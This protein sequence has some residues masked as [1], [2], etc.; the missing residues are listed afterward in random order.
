MGTTAAVLALPFVV[1]GQA[2][3]RQRVVW[4]YENSAGNSPEVRKRIADLLAARGFVEGRNL[5]LSFQTFPEGKEDV[6]AF[7]KRLVDSAPDVIVRAP[8]RR[9]GWLPLLARSTLDIPIVFYNLAA[10]PA[11]VGLVET[12]RRPGGNITGATV[13]WNEIGTRQWQLLKSFVP[14]MKRGGIL[15]EQEQEY[16][17]WEAAKQATDETNR[18]TEAQLG[19]EIREVSFR[20]GASEPEIALAISKAR[21]DAVRVGLYPSEL[22]PEVIAALKRTRVPACGSFFSQVKRGLLVCVTFDFS[23]GEA[24]AIDTVARIL[25]GERPATIPVSKNTK[26]P[27]AVNRGTARAM[28][29]EIPASIL[30]QASEIFD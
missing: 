24:Y 15:R 30:I 14:S 7:V 20:R 21:V 3:R 22:T 10:D 26:Y 17:T 1:L 29:I 2:T 23:E 9:G 18:R 5:S 6:E 13:D 19:I 25:R 27:V 8:G 12:L 16:P 28:G 4:L 11:T